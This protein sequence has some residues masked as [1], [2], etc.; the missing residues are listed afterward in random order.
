MMSL[1]RAFSGWLGKKPFTTAD[2]KMSLFAAISVQIQFL[3]G[4]GMYFVSPRSQPG[5]MAAAMKDDV[6]RFFTVE[7]TTIMLIGITLVSIG[8]GR[9]RKA[10]TDLAKHKVL[11]IFLLIGLLVIFL[12]IPWPFLRDFGTWF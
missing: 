11:A 2:D 3:I 7:H 4:L 5:D 1:F 9:S 8:R 10:T 12:G 6:L